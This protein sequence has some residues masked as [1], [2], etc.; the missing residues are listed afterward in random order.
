MRNNRYQIAESK[1]TRRSF[2]EVAGVGSLLLAGSAISGCSNPQETPQESEGAVVDIVEETIASMTLEHKIAQLFIVAPEAITGVG[3]ATQ[4]GDATRAALASNP[5]GGIVY[6]AQNLLDPE[7]TSDMLS[8]TAQYGREANGLP[9]FLAVDEEGGTVAR[10]ANNEA[11]SQVNTGDAADIGAT[12]DT[13]QASAAAA[14]IASYLVP[15][16]FNLNFAPV[17]DIADNPQSDIMRRRSFGGDAQLVS[18]MG[19]AQ[20]EAFLDG[21]ILCC[22]KHFPGIGSAENDSHE[23]QIFSNKTLEEMRENELIPFTAAIEAGVPMIMMGHLSTPL[24]TENDTPASLSRTLV[25]DLLRG[26]LNYEGIVITDALNMA[27]A[28]SLHESDELA[29]LAIEAGCDIALM[30][31]DY[32]ASYKKLLEAV[33]SGRIAESRIEESLRRILRVKFAL[34]G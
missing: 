6:F 14:S 23:T 5:V 34:E 17:L 33:Q 20:I 2:V 15:L 3:V 8:N 24:I 30:P 1:M 28:G 16:G 26:E 27:A 22:A 32:E 21:D 29:V 7:Q 25:T 13:A 31:L 18:D 10:I 12:N 11:F 19:C 9:L 4:A